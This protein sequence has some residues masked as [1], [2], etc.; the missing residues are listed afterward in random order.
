MLILE[1]YWKNYKND[2]QNC[3]K[4]NVY[5][6]YNFLYNYRSFKKILS[7]LKNNNFQNSK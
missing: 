3:Y 5:S 2:L 7:S 1:F 4:K 6:C